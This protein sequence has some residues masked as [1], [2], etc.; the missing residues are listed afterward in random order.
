MHEK[1]QLFVTFVEKPATSHTIVLKTRTLNL[2]TT[3]PIETK[4]MSSLMKRIEVVA[5]VGFHIT[6]RVP[7]KEI[8]RIQTEG[9]AGVISITGEDM[10]ILWGVMDIQ[11]VV[12]DILSEDM[13]NQGVNRHT[14]LIFST[15]DLNSDLIIELE[16]ETGIVVTEMIINLEGLW[17]M[18]FAIR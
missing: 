5:I 13:G 4:I 17:K 16:T 15:Q 11:L 10:V 14:N 3:Y 12:M 18:L 1:P 9:V 6:D 8:F 7:T 2:N